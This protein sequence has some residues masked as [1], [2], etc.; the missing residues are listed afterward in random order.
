MGRKITK[1][2]FE[3]CKDEAIKYETRNKFQ[4]KQWKFL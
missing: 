1:W 3:A 4:K 2:T